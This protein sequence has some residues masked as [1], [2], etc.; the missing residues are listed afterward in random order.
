MRWQ[1]AFAP[2]LGNVSRARALASRA[3]EDAELAA[4]PSVTSS[5]YSER[6]TGNA[7]RH[8]RTEF[9]ASVIVS[10]RIVRVEVFDRNPRPPSL[11]D[12]D[13]ESTSGRG[14][15]LVAAIAL[16]WGWQTARDDS[17]VAGKLVWAELRAE[18]STDLTMASEPTDPAT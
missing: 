18:L 17:G 10:G 3:L 11:L 13:E 16:G 15:H 14:L 2:D 6:L 7:V 1:A 5:S 4:P 9:T 12:L 8:A